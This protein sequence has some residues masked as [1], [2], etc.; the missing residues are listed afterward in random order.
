MGKILLPNNDKWQFVLRRRTDL[1]F[2]DFR[3]NSS[4]YNYCKS[5][6]IKYFF[7]LATGDSYFLNSHSNQLRQRGYR[8]LVSPTS[9][10]K[11]LSNKSEF[12][13]FMINSGLG[14][15]IPKR[16]DSIQYPCVLKRNRSMF[17]QQTYI[18]NSKHDIPSGIKIQKIHKN[19]LIQE[20][21]IGPCEYTTDILAKNGKIYM[22]TTLKYCY[23]SSLYVMGTDLI[24]SGKFIETLPE[25]V[26]NVFAAIVKKVNYSGFC[27]ID[28]K[29][30]EDGIP[31]IFEINPRCGGS[32]K[33]IKRRQYMYKYL[34][35]YTELAE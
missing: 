19:Y 23:K 17:G 25:K 10:I 9:T 14:N 21:I 13:D 20:P 22:Y 8:Y 24:S 4:F 30:T 5:K 33:N 11:M 18:I 12:V 29:I 2:A 31:K 28:Y 34:D 35:L 6:D 32:L 3:N 7:P 26:Y 1:K 16:Y 27:N 15:Y